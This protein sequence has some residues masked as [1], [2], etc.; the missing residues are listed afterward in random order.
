MIILDGQKGKRC[1]EATYLT[2]THKKCPCCR[3][4]KAVSL[5]Y[6]KKA[7][8][9]RGWAWDSKCI[10][11]RRS[12][13]RSYGVSNRERRN[14]RLRAWRKKN[15]Q[16]ARRHDKE[17]RLKQKYGLSIE[18][19]EAIRQ[20]QDGR[21]AICEKKTHRLFI[22]HCHTKGHF[23]ALICQTCNTFLGWYEKK[24]E[25]ILRFQAYITAHAK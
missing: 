5:F 8:T 2:Y 19:V 23:R 21:C 6:K 11:C 25:T 15:P 16:A 24:A 17:C 7:Q 10:D 4:V 20:R 14:A 1:D 13:C 9:A 22:D 3:R 18:Q 12:D